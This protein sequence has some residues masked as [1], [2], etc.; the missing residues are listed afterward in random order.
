[1][2]ARYPSDTKF[3]INAWTPGYEVR[4]FKYYDPATL[5]HSHRSLQ[6][7]IGGTHRDR[8]FFPYQGKSVP[9][10]ADER[11]G[12]LISEHQIHVDRYKYRLYTS[13]SEPIFK[14]ILTT[15][16]SATRFHACER[17]NRCDE[18]PHEAQE[19]VYVN[20]Q[21]MPLTAWQ[22]YHSDTMN[23]LAQGVR[24]TYLVSRTSDL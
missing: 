14:D 7:S 8:P 24:P 9:P 11:I 6:L 4:I 3:F 12:Q 18:V 20:P 2:M 17:F 23:G 15:D 16:P 10:R 5:M 19:V 21:D 22:K 1:M 13:I